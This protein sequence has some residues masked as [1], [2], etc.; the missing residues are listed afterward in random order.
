MARMISYHATVNNAV[1]VSYTSNQ[2]STCQYRFT[3]VDTKQQAL[4]RG[5]STQAM[6]RPTSKKIGIKEK[7]HL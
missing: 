2:T 3:W 5:L 7:G 1:L 6:L 4:H